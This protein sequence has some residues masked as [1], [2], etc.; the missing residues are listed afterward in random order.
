VVVGNEEK[1]LQRQENCSINVICTGEV[2]FELLQKEKVKH[3]T[4]KQEPK[5]KFTKK[6]RDKTT[7]SESL[8]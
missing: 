6:V 7:E 1:N 4:W 8:P 5:E 2:N 3:F